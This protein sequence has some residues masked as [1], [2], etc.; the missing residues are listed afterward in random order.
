MMND[1]N[2]SLDYVVI[3]STDHGKAF[4]MTAV[5]S[6]YWLTELIRPKR[7]MTG[8]ITIKFTNINYNSLRQS[9]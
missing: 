6:I 4:P 2:L 1:L 3:E 5:K 8:R 9:C 7:I